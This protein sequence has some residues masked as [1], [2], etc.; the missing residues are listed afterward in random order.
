MWRSRGKVLTRLL[1]KEII[2]PKISMN[3]EKLD[4]INGQN[5]IQFCR[6]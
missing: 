5:I 2:G 6:S 3:I 4:T 1:I